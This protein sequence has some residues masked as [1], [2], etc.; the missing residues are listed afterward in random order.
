MKTIDEQLKDVE[1]RL[2][3]E[4]SRR[5]F[6]RYQT[7]RL[8]L[9]GHDNAA[10]AVSIGRKESTVDTYLRQYRRQGLDGLQMKFSPGPPE[11]LS[12]EQQQQLKKTI[13]DHIP[14]DV[15]YTAKFNWTLELIGDYI[16]R[17]FGRRYS[18][19]GVSKLMHRMDLSYTKPTYTLAA[20]DEEKQRLFVESTFPRLKKL[21]NGEI[22]HLLFEDES[23]IRDYQALQKTW[24]AK[25]KQRIIKTTGKHR[26]VKL[27]A[28]LDYAE[29]TIVWKEDEQYNAESFLAFLEQ[30]LAAYPTGKIVMVL[31]N[32]RIH[33]A[34]LLSSFLQE[35]KSRL[36]LVFLPPYS[37][38]LNLV[39]GL[40]KWLKADVI[41][42][43][44]Y[45]TTAEIRTNVQAFMDR[46]M[47]E[48][49]K[50]IDRLCIRM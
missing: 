1:Q 33:H 49:L 23:M 10:I 11:Q 4:K 25:G 24:F 28:T 29:G 38:E 2:K 18:I 14:H 8:H 13:C 15:G 47:K 45:H 39:E 27:L 50:I 19:R 35:N 32:A 22:D 46:I 48:P 7:V 30:V 17:E 34:K 12:K 21:E 44:F 20:A 31:D 9:L 43:V 26:G 41:N 40:W 37:P 16:S 6:E 36:K 5:M 3:H 42:N